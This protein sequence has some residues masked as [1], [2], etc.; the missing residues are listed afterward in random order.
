LLNFESEI[1]FL[2]KYFKDILASILKIMENVD[3][4]FLDEKF[5]FIYLEDKNN[6]K[7]GENKI[8]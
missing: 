2:L 8:R 1:C 6:H 4:F 5:L 7:Y 3:I